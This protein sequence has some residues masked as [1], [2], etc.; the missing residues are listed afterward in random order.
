[1]D[2]MTRLPCGVKAL[3]FLEGIRTGQ[4]LRVVETAEGTI[5]R[6]EEDDESGAVTLEL[7]YDAR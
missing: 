5:L 3:E 6:I 7:V 1:M 4:L 2:D